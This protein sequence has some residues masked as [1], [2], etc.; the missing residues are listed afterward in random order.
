MKKEIVKKEKWV[1]AGVCGV[2]SGQIHIGDPCYI[3]EDQENYTACTGNKE[4][5]GSQAYEQLKHKA[6]HDGLGVLISGFGG[7]GIFPVYIKR[8]KKG[9]MQE[10]KIIFKRVTKI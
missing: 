10:A 9:L 5:L 2:D 7:D 4:I 8:D 6:G 1:W 3:F